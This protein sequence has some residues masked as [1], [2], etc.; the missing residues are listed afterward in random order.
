MTYLQ[1]VHECGKRLFHSEE[2]SWQ[3]VRKILREDLASRDEETGGGGLAGVFD[4]FCADVPAAEIAKKRFICSRTIYAQ[5]QAFTLDGMIYAAQ[6]GIISMK[7]RE[8]ID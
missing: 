5:K 8:F 6:L 2:P 4:D 3:F 1:F 7:R